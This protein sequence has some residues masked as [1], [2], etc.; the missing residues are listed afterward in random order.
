MASETAIKKGATE[1]SFR[2]CAKD[3]AG[4]VLDLSGKELEARFKGGDTPVLV[5]GAAVALTPPDVD[6]NG[7]E[8]NY[9]YDWNAGD[10]DM[11]GTYQHELW[12]T[13]GPGAVQKFPDKQADNPIL[14]IEADLE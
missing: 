11:P 1:P 12:V 9:R 8:W 14:K 10:T 6:P 4:N 13:T 2:G 5:K 7:D 3:G